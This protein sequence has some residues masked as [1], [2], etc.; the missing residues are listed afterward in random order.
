M[1]T[2]LDFSFYGELRAFTYSKEPGDTFTTGEAVEW[3]KKANP[4]ADVK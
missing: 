2:W 3:V 1:R 4:M